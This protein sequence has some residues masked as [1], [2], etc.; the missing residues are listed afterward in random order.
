MIGGQFWGSACPRIGTRGPAPMRNVAVGSNSP[1]LGL[2]A[3]CAG[4]HHFVRSWG[5]C[6]GTTLGRVGGQRNTTKPSRTI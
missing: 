1:S 4:G 6:N 2:G 3:E 5:L